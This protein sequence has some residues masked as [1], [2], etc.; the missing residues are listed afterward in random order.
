MFTI[1]YRPTVTVFFNTRY[2]IQLTPR[3]VFLLLRKL[4]FNPSRSSS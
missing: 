2:E 1:F 3:Q 4:V